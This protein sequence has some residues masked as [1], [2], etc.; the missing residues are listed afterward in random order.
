[1]REPYPQGDVR[2]C[3]SS[4][5]DACG[6][7]LW[8]RRAP[9]AVIKARTTTR[10]A[11]PGDKCAAWEMVR[12]EMRVAVR[13]KKPAAG[14]PARACDENSCDVEHMQVICPTA[15]EKKVFL[16]PQDRLP[17]SRLSRARLAIARRSTFESSSTQWRN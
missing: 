16:A 7:G 14:F 5:G 13:L 15:Q 10:F 11:T 3:G 6:R 17:C 8:P 4:R 12:P 9:A 2:N 1:M